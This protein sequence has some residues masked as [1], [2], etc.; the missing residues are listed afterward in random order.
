LVRVTG[1]P[2]PLERL[3]LW[4]N[5]KEGRKILRYSGV[6]VISTAVSFTVLFLVYG[7][8]HIWSEVPSTVFANT[9]ATFPSY[10]LNRNWAWGKSGRSHLMKEVVPFWVMSAFGITFS[11]VG[12]S[13]ASHLSH[14]RSHTEATVLVLL[15]NLVSF[16]IFWLAKLAVFNRL[17]HVPSL[18]EE[19]DEHIDAEAGEATE[20]VS[21]R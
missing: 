8:G 3:L 6:S 20:D 5:T 10:W 14:G 7:V 18:L 9:V 21:L 17:F 16:G 15:A 12:A 13:V 2:E 4:L 19:I 11:I 1:V